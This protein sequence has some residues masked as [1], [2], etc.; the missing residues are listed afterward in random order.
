MKTVQ[1]D[2]EVYRLRFIHEFNVAGATVTEADVQAQQA[3]AL[4]TAL[5]ERKVGEH[6]I[7]GRSEW[8][9]TAKGHAALSVSEPNVHHPEFARQLALA[10]LFVQLSRPLAGRLLGSYMASAPRR[11]LMLTKATIKS[12]VDGSRLEDIWTLPDAL[13]WLEQQERARASAA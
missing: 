11:L 9:V 1:L 4:T 6:V 7:T 10:R 3:V 5:V 8:M 2:G 12:P 13:K